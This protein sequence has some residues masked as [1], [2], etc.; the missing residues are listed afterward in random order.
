[1][2]DL[3]LRS[4]RTM[5][6]VYGCDHDFRCLTFSLYGIKILCLIVPLPESN[7]FTHRL[8]HF[9]ARNVFDD[10]DDIFADIDKISKKTSSKPKKERP[11]S[12]PKPPAADDLFGERV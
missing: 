5:W 12:D 4:K 6:L 11:T 8:I 7:G 10:D 9:Q 2:P 3:H 1:M